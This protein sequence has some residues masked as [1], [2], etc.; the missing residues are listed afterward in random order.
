MRTVTGLYARSIQWG[1]C[2]LGLYCEDSNVSVLRGQSVTVLNNV[3]L[4][5]EDTVTLHHSL[6]QENQYSL[7]I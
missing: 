2:I 1:I 6:K 7:A 5:C 4:Y 3:S